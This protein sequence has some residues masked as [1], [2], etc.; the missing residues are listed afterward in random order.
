MTSH[1]AAIAKINQLPDSLAQEVSDFVDLLLI[2]HDAT[3]QQLWTLF[4]EGTELAESDLADYLPHL[5]EYEEKLARKEI[6]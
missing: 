2:K 1:E 3:R 6:Q 4:A 5:E